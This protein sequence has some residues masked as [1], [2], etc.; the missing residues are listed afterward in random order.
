MTPAS[1]QLLSDAT[2]LINRFD[3]QTSGH[4]FEI[5]LTSN[6]DLIDYS[7]DK[8]Q[9]QIIL[10]LDSGLENNLGEIIIPQNLVIK[11][12]LGSDF[13]KKMHLNYVNE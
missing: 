5:K 12:K 8:D 13:G 1:G 9:K 4:T 2:G 10:Y 7:F 6:F 3:V 11:I